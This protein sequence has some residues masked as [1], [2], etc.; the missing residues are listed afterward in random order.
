MLASAVVAGDSASKTR[1]NALSGFQPAS[2]PRRFR[3]A[4]F[5]AAMISG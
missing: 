1:M 2:L 3:A 5:T 4:D